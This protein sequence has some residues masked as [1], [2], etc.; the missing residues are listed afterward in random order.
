M[1]AGCLVSLWKHHTPY[2]EDGQIHSFSQFHLLIVENSTFRYPVLSASCST[3]IGNRHLHHC[4]PSSMMEPTTS[5]AMLTIL[6]DP[7]QMFCCSFVLCCHRLN[8][9]KSFQLFPLLLFILHNNSCLPSSCFGS[10]QT[11]ASIIQ[12]QEKRSAFISTLLLSY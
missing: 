6:G 10:V 8:I 4:P 11:N 3:N 2:S 12:L 7:N 5:L 9:S 1:Y